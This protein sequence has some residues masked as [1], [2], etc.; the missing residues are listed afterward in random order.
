ML[1]SSLCGY[2]DEYIIV[3]GSITAINTTQGQPIVA[4]IKR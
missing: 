2:G 3:K 1:R 4:P